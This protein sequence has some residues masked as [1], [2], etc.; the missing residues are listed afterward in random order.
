MCH[1]CFEGIKVE[2][3]FSFLENQQEKA[4]AGITSNMKTMKEVNKIATCSG[5]G[6]RE[7]QAPKSRPRRPSG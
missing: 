3:K 7:G 5:T 1:V 2:E 6:L 4:K